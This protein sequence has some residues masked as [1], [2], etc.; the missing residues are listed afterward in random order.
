[1]RLGI[2][3][4]GTFTDLVLIDDDSGQIHYTKTLSTPTDLAR[5]VVTGIADILRLTEVGSDALD[6]VVH[7]T[8]VGTNALIERKG[9]K[10]GL[11][12][13]AGFRDV[14]EIARIERPDAGLY[15]M[16]VD[17]PEPLV[18][19]YL[20]LEADE[21]VGADGS[22]VRDL[23]ENSV[24]HAADIFE[25]EGVE[26]VAVCLLFSFRNPKH[27]QLIQEVVKRL[28]PALPV[29]LSSEIAPE[30]REFERSSTCVINAYLL[31]ITRSYVE[32]LAAE[33]SAEFGLSDLRIMQASGGAMTADVAKSHAV[34]MVN[35]GPA[36]GALASAVF[37][38]LAGEDRIIGVDMG[39]TSFDVSLIVDGKPRLKSEGE[40]EGYPV[41][42]PMIDVEGIG[43]GGGSIAWVDSGGALNVG[44]RSAGADPGPACYGLG[45]ELPTVTDANLVLG[46]LNPDYFL[47]AEMQLHVKPARETVDQHVAKPLDLSIEEAAAGII[48]VVN[49]NM[50]RGI[51]V[52]STQK[53]YDLREFSLLAFGG[54]GPLHAVE[55]AQE[56]GMTR[57]II[58]PYCS[59][60]SAFGAVAS[61]VRHD[62]VQ[63]VAWSE[64]ELEAG[65]MESAFATL[66]ARATAL[67]EEEKVP[68]EQIRLERSADVRYEGQSYELTIPL[69]NPGRLKGGDVQKM[70]KHF[71]ARHQQIYAYSDPK[72]S[73]EVISLRLAAEGIVPELQLKSSAQVTGGSPA[74]KSQ[75][76]IYFPG[77]GF[78]DS[79]VYEREDL[80]A[81]QAM[82]GPSLIE[83]RT[84]T[85]VIPIGW[86]ARID[87]HGNIVVSPHSDEESEA[88]LESMRVEA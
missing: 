84:S 31:P 66:K 17:L 67:L 46:R 77:S 45:G 38:R 71:H 1:M 32:S 54:A 44:P 81:G 86:R 42:M 79:D 19:R 15:D 87:T 72:E 9:A 39:G 8:T 78:L 23:D 21:R 59:V 22:V 10:V 16:T 33:L 26:A 35:S 12:T 48:R 82:L 30:F 36:G 68:E 43:A 62:Y 74:P 40:F 50:V 13:T 70:I 55:L 27:E 88:D 73:V 57:V 6:Y 65:S 3:V 2:D 37:G 47:G 52:N 75:R 85:T 64:A 11:I 5:A 61:D 63:T 58:P 53:G 29:T 20:R 83:E 14:L 56:L 41:K 49:A 60:F 34:H 51:S 18:P 25:R 76:P 4:G 24:A 80:L 69:R 7:G 28:L